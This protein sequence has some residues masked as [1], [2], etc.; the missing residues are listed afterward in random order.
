MYPPTAITGAIVRTCACAP[1][2][3]PARCPIDPTSLAA[4]WCSMHEHACMRL[5]VR[6]VRLLTTPPSPSSITHM[7]VR[8][9]ISVDC[10][11]C[12]IC[13]EADAAKYPHGVGGVEARTINCACARA[14]DTNVLQPWPNTGHAHLA[15]CARCRHASPCMSWKRCAWSSCKR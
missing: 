11:G 10:L 6:I 3:E 7:H 1:T 15:S 4:A 9:G 8:H 14:S 2:I 13:D 5:H 12:T